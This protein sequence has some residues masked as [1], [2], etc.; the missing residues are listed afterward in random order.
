MHKYQIVDLAQ[1]IFTDAPHWPAHPATSIEAI[2]WHASGAPRAMFLHMCDHSQ[3]HTDALNHVDDRSTAPG[4]DRIPLGSFLTRGI[5]LDVTGMVQARQEISLELLR[6]VL[7]R[8]NLVPP[9]GGT[10]L[11]TTGHYR[12]TF[13]GA[14]YLTKY[15]GLSEEAAGYLYLDCG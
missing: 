12:R 7:D 10:V 1:E 3:T 11:V 4:V 2:A 6:E 15:A 14:D 8:T 5:A 13:P 9:R